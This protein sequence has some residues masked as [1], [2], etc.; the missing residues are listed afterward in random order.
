MW[1]LRSKGGDDDDMVHV[2]LRSY[3]DDLCKITQG[4]ERRRLL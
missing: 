1:L 3:E 4:P 2:P